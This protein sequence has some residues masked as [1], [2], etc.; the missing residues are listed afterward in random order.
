MSFDDHAAIAPPGPA[1]EP[2]LNL[3]WTLV[4]LA[5]QL[6]ILFW[7][8]A[9]PDVT[10]HYSAQGTRTLSYVLNVQHSIYRGRI[11][12]GE[13]TG[14]SGHIFPD[15]D[16]F[17]QFDWWSKDSRDCVEI[18]PKWPETHLYID[19]NGELDRRPESGTDVDRLSPCNG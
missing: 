2:P 8:V 10:V 4:M 13:S 15:A 3:T 12:P 14:D 9:K 19:A 17:M 5:I 16:F 11:E 6:S 7:Y 18:N 1:S